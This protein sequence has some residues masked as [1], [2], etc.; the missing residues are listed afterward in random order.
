M[1]GTGSN[2]TTGERRNWTCPNPTGS[3]TS[4]GWVWD[5]TPGVF[6]DNGDRRPSVPA[7]VLPTPSTQSEVESRPATQRLDCPVGQVGDIYQSRQEQRTRIRTAYCPAPT[8]SFSWGGWSGWSAW[9]ATGSWATTSNTCAP[10]GNVCASRAERTGGF[11]SGTT[12]GPWKRCNASNLGQRYLTYA[13]CTPWGLRAP[14]DPVLA[15]SAHRRVGV[16]RSSALRPVLPGLI[17]RRKASRTSTGWPPA[18]FHT[19]LTER[20]SARSRYRHWLS[21]RAR[22]SQPSPLLCLQGHLLKPHL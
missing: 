20:M 9:T 18:T 10:V 22:N 12:A 17:W 11:S 3:P 7:C 21:R 5:G 8:G 15:T 2:W 19:L 13:A 6:V 14:A 16:C 1:T 4:S